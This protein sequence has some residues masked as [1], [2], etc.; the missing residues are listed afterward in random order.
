MPTSKQSSTSGKASHHILE[1]LSTS[2]LESE[3]RR[4]DGRWFLH[5]LRLLLRG[6]K[7][8]P[9]ASFWSSA[10][11]RNDIKSMVTWEN[12]TDEYGQ[13]DADGDAPQQGVTSLG[14]SPTKSGTAEATESNTFMQKDF[15]F[16]LQEEAVYMAR[17]NDPKPTRPAIPPNP[18]INDPMRTC[19]SESFLS[20]W[21]SE[22]ANVL[23]KT[24]QALTW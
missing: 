9:N 10:C 4:H 2:W 5:R 15:I 23:S 21:M 11:V 7:K 19:R 13:N 24:L 1:H 8:A 3:C 20:S 17:G 14:T 18:I 16:R 12:E 6:L 22:S